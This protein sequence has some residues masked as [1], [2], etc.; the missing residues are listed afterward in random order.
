MSILLHLCRRPRKVIAIQIWSNVVKVPAP[1]IICKADQCIE[2]ILVELY[3]PTHQRHR[4][5][6][7]FQTFGVTYRYFDTTVDTADEGRSI[8]L[9]QV[10]PFSFRDGSV[11]AIAL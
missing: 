11:D 10:F 8:R 5:S 7:R 9:K 4:L 1:E 3:S 2:L 6:Q